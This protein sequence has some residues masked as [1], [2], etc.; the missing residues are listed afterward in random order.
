MTGVLVDKST[1]DNGE[2]HSPAAE[3]RRQIDQLDPPGTDVL[4]G[5]GRRIGGQGPGARERA[6]GAGTDSPRHRVRHTVQRARGRPRRVT[7][8]RD[9]PDR[10][11]QRCPCVGVTTHLRP[12]RAAVAA[13]HDVAT[14][15]LGDD[16]GVHPGMPADPVTNLGVPAGALSFAHA[17]QPGDGLGERTSGPRQRDPLPASRLRDD[18]DRSAPVPG[19]AVADQ[20]N[21][22]AGT[23]SGVAER[24]DVEQVGALDRRAGRVGQDDRIGRRRRHR[25]TQT[26]VL[27]RVPPVPCRRAE[28]ARMRAATSSGRDRGRCSAPDAEA[29][30][31]HDPTPH[32][33]RLPAEGSA[34]AG[35]AEPGPIEHQGCSEPTLRPA[36]P[37]CQLARR[38]YVSATLRPTPPTA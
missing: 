10:M 11:R 30:E 3:E 27:A 16:H 36:S 31:H 37:A 26:R 20:R 21:D 33:R 22:A 17:W 12:E 8:D 34:G 25:Q 1:A 7:H 29:E 15:V 5:D 13:G 6:G 2:A 23:R 19:M 14:D 35:W 28:A 4:C 18:L 38:R 32:A 9:P 24:A